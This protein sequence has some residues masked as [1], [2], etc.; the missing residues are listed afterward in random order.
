MYDG[1]GADGYM[2]G[3]LDNVRNGSQREM[4][5]STSLVPTNDSVDVR[6]RDRKLSVI[7]VQLS[8][9]DRTL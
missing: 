1:A 9:S 7:Y 6:H 5:E 8:L 2:N 3:L 4:Q